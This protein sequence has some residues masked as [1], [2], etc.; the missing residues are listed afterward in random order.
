MFNY[1]VR[2]VRGKAQDAKTGR[3]VYHGDSEKG[4]PRNKHA[5]WHSSKLTPRT[6]LTKPILSPASLP[7]SFPQLSF[8][9]LEMR[10]FFPHKQHKVRWPHCICKLAVGPIWAAWGKA[11]DPL[12]PTSLWSAHSYPCVYSL[13]INQ[14]L[15]SQEHTIVTTS[16]TALSWSSLANIHLEQ[17]VYYL[18]S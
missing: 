14:E 4:P 12:E 2:G 6:T 9:L 13:K 15:P 10:V 17:H 18:A 5:G 16:T 3:P 7:F 11:V 1:F 8:P